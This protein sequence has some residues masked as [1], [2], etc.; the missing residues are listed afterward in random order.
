MAKLNVIL[1]IPFIATGCSG[2]PSTGGSAS[3]DGSPSVGS[4]YELVQ[5]VD[6][7][8]A[9]REHRINKFY[10]PTIVDADTVHFQAVCSAPVENPCVFLAK[11]GKLTPLFTPSDSPYAMRGP[12]GVISDRSFHLLG[13]TVAS[14]H[15]GKTTRILSWDN[16]APN[17]SKFSRFAHLDAHGDLLA[18]F[19]EYRDEL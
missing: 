4:S 1:L 17:G 9:P 18:F 10:P 19:G 12:Y 5:V 3:T 13:E 16:T 14:F 6:A 2:S 15:N 11:G 7:N 8:S